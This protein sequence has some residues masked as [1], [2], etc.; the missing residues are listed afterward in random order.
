[1]KCSCGCIL[2]IFMLFIGNNVLVI[3]NNVVVEIENKVL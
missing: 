1:M 2:G 3:E